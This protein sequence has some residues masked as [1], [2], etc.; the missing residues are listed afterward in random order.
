MLILLKD[1]SLE[2][3]THIPEIVPSN[4]LNSSKPFPDCLQHF[5]ELLFRMF[6]IENKGNMKTKLD[7]NCG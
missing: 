5:Y 4:H 7:M 3:L 2:L 6:L 1:G